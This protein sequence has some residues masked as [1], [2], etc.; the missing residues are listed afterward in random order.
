M[1]Y[2]WV[3][4]VLTDLKAFAHANG[5]SALADHLDETLSVATA[6]IALRRGDPAGEEAG[7]SGPV[8]LG[9]SLGDGA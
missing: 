9:P 3:L 2:D 5:L 8:Q 6:E 7:P 1:R 4:D